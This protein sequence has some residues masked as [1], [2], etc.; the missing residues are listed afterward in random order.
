MQSEPNLRDLVE[1]KRTIVIP[2]LKLPDQTKLVPSLRMSL[3]QSLNDLTLTQ[4]QNSV[5]SSLDHRK[6]KHAMAERQTLTGRIKKPEGSERDIDPSVSNAVCSRVEVPRE[7]DI[8]EN[9]LSTDRISCRDKLRENLSSLNSRYQ[10]YK[11]APSFSH[12]LRK[13]VTVNDLTS[14]ISDSKRDETSIASFTARNLQDAKAKFNTKI[15]RSVPC[16]SYSGQPAP[17]R[18]LESEQ[19]DLGEK[20]VIFFHANGEDLNQLKF[21][22]EYMGRT[23]NTSVLAPEYPGYSLYSGQPNEEQILE[24]A[25]AVYHFAVD[26][27]K[28]KPEQILVVGRS[29]GSG[30]A[31]YL[32]SK[33]PVLGLLLVSPFASIKEVVK[34]KVGMLLSSCVRQRFD[35]LALISSVKCKLRIV[36]G[37][38]DDVVSVDQSKA[39]AGSSR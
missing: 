38:K 34:E 13:K 19:G 36:H 6:F 25:D 1:S 27:L 31:I 4:E 9:I 32:A 37:E 5:R 12:H 35:N 22:F 20:L 15:K 2:K 16:L 28:L 11:L 29:L 30:P 10:K 26:H 21:F 23:L 3:R 17:Q 39:L 18:D 33:Y 14:S 7:E 8:N 24:D